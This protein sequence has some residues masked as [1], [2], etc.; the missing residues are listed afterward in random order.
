MG[1]CDH[2]IMAVRSRVLHLQAGMAGHHLRRAAEARRRL[3]QRDR[4]LVGTVTQVHGGGADPP[5]WASCGS[6]ASRPANL[7]SSVTSQFRSPPRRSPA[8]SW[9]RR[10][11]PEFIGPSRST[12]SAPDHTTVKPCAPPTQRFD[13]SFCSKPL[14]A[15]TNGACEGSMVAFSAGRTDGTGQLRRSF[16]LPVRKG[17]AG[18]APDHAAAGDAVFADEAGPASASN[19]ASA[20]PLGGGVH[21]TGGRS[22]LSFSQLGGG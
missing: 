10:A 15:T 2:C 19:A 18:L 22:P 17:A 4:D 6:A 11:A 12:S 1:D 16:S 21:V 13:M 14:C 20:P 9:R 5:G 3:G 8:V 7:A